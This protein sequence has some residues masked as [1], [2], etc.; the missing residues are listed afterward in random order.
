MARNLRSLEKKERRQFLR[1]LGVG[2]G[3]VV[4]AG[5]TGDD[6]EGDSTDT[7]N[8]NGGSSNPDELLFVSSSPFPSVDPAKIGG[9]AGLFSNYNLYDPL[10]TVNE[11]L[12]LIGG[13][14]SDWESDDAQTWTVQ[15]EEGVEFH[16]GGLM[17]AEDVVYTT[18]RAQSVGTG[19]TSLWTQ[20]IDSVDAIDDTTVE[21]NL[22]ETF[23]PFPTTL[24]T[25]FVVDKSVV[26][27]AEGDE[28]TEYLE[29]NS[30]GTGPYTLDERVTDNYQIYTQFDNYYRGW[31]DN[32]IEQIRVQIVTEE[33]TVRQLMTTGEGHLT[34]Q[35]LSPQAYEEIGNSDKARVY[36][37]TQPS[38]YHLMMNTQREPFDD[39]NVRRAFNLVYNSQEAAENIWGSGVLA[40]TPVPPGIPGRNEELE[41]IGHDVEAAQAA[42]EE[43]SYSAD[44]INDIGIT[45]EHAAG[46]DRQRRS[47][48]LLQNNLSDIDIDI[49]VTATPWTQITDRVPQRETS[50]DVMSATATANIPSPDVYTYQMHH[51]SQLGSYL[52]AAWYSSDD[53][54]ETLEQARNEPDDEARNALYREAQKLIMNAYPSIHITYAPFQVGINEQ[55]GG[56][57]DLKI[58]GASHQIYNMRWE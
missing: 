42:I 48:L 12:E 41:P 56:F 36:E 37:S 30:A 5:C 35:Y 1:M 43:S 14:A 17:T 55:V 49:E 24:A 40:S 28:G 57:T 2:A 33:S 9:F 50:P 22:T 39:V 6:S 53:L 32:A 13:L 7:G 34:D 10:I 44:E 27:D 58:L 52:S 31:D 18:K 47:T 20:V 16:D 15:L 19:V 51:P 11:D 4:L 54:T 23:G 21:F 29:Q 38:M 46:F 8:G 3:S 45:A 25:H 26:Q